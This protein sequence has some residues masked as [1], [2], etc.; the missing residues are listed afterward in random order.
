MCPTIGDLNIMEG[1][2]TIGSA[3]ILLGTVDDPWTCRLLVR[4]YGGL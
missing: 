2:W 3:V 1:F 4:F